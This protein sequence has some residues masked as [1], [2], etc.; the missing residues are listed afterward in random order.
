M[1]HFYMMTYFAS[2][3]HC[4]IKKKLGAIL[5]SC[6]AF[7]PHMFC[8]KIQGSY[9]NVVMEQC[10]SLELF[11]CLFSSGAIHLDCQCGLWGSQSRGQEC[12]QCQL[13]HLLCFG[14]FF[15]SQ[16]LQTWKTMSEADSSFQDQ[17]TELY[18]HLLSTW[19][20]QVEKKSETIMTASVL[21]QDPNTEDK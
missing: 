9:S 15:Q 16:I 6:S 12:Q 13:L 1:E 5:L 19:H 8:L 7:P 20:M 14:H 21:K 18:D 11:T 17:L 10:W 2:D 4:Y 3:G